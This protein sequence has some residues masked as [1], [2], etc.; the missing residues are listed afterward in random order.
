MTAFIRPAPFKINV[1]MFSAS[2]WWRYRTV[3]GAATSV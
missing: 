2:Y 3:E 1:S